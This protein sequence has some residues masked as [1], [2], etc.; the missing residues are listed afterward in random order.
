MQC[1][2]SPLVAYWVCSI[3]N[4]LLQQN[5]NVFGD[6]FKTTQA[7]CSK[8]A[9]LVMISAPGDT[10]NP[11][12]SS[13]YGNKTAIV[14]DPSVTVRSITHFPIIQFFQTGTN[15]SFVKIKNHNYY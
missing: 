12:V 8:S 1:L 2:A 13:N 9:A 7:M 10:I 3:K 15:K 14:L 6:A 4:F 11:T 5:I